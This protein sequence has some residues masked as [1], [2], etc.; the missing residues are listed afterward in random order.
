MEMIVPDVT[1][2]IIIISQCLSNVLIASTFYAVLC[3]AGNFLILMPV[4]RILL[5]THDTYMTGHLK[6]VILHAVI[7]PTH[8]H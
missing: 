3:Q 4:V 5:S 8:D 6:P 1:K 2:C 7:T